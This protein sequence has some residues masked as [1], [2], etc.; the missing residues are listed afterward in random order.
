MAQKL[1][2]GNSIQPTRNVAMLSKLIKSVE[3]R[4]FGLPGLAIFHGPPGFGKSFSCAHA[5]VHLDAIH[6]TC[7]D[8]WTKKQLLKTILLE[9]NKEPKGTM[10]DL[11]EKAKTAL[12][13]ASRTLIID[14]ADDAVAKNLVPTIRHLHDGSSVPVI[15]VGMEFLSEKLKKWDLVASRV[16]DWAAAQPADLHDLRLLAKRYAAETKID[17][18]LL[19]KVR[20]VTRG[21]HR[22][23]ATDLAHIQREAR[24]E[25]EPHMTLSKWGGRKFFSQREPEPRDFR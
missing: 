4:E 21:V 10:A 7:D 23:L 1:N 15:F 16:Y 19:E 18:A 5:A 24:T 14:E 17:D 22:V 8:T 2:L 25:G 13:V 20:E 6:I 3:A 11:M 9:L 12:A